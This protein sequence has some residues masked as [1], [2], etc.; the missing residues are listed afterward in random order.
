MQAI[1]KLSVATVAAKTKPG[2]YADG[3]GLYL[4][5]AK[6]GSKTW[7]FRF[8][9]AG[10]PR[11]M[12]LGPVHTVSLKLAREKAQECR[13]KLLDADD[14]IEARKVARMEKLALSATAMTFEEAAE[15]YIKAQRAGWK[16]IKHADQ[17]KATLATY[18][19]PVFGNLGVGRVDV[20]LVMKAIEPIWQTKTET[21]S[22]LRGRIESVLDWA[23]ARG[24]RTGE[25]PARWKGHLENLLPARS[26]VAKVQ[27]HAAL[28]YAELPSFMAAVRGLDGVSPKA[29]EFAILTATRTGETVGARWSEIDIANAM[30]IIPGARMKAGREHRIPLSARA[31]A[32]LE[33]LPREAGND[34]VFIGDKKGGHLSNMALLMTLRRM[35]RAD[36]TTHG[37]RSTFRDW[38]AE[39]TAYPTELC[40]MA[41]AHTV[42]DKVEAAYR[43][44]DMLDKRRR[45]MKDWADF[46]HLP[47][48]GKVIP[49]RSGLNG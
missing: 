3:L 6:G 20:G 41:L 16:S 36:L 31:V 14:P 33:S 38:A 28:P 44:G 26:K 2:L 35:G 37:F 15:Q 23:A 46:C 40:E 5:V 24:L 47:A 19:Y 8:M 12:G 34:S 29:L 21:A 43:R 22:R 9:L 17:W 49:I 45:L 4:Q 27:H 7:I 18:A 1:N 25:N 11:K 32:L 30:W 48:S 42:S 13:L 10:R 39:Q